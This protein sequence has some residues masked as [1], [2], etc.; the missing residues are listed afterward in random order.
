MLK[1]GF[2]DKATDFSPR[3]VIAGIENKSGCCEKD[4]SSR[5]THPGAG[6]G[7][8][9]S[10]NCTDSCVRFL[11]LVPH[12]SGHEHR[13]RAVV[14]VA[15][16]STP[17]P[18]PSPKAGRRSWAPKHPKARSGTGIQVQRGTSRPLLFVSV[19]KEVVFSQITGK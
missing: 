13:L 9:T 7:E 5:H 4:S 16:P 10:G 6:D 17:P 15:V 1:D 11:S 19:R 12:I 18:A 8:N 14:P 3:L 2:G